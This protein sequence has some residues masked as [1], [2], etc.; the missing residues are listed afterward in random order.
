M[1]PKT[2][3]SVMHLA[4]TAPSLDVFF[5][6][7][8]VSNT[9][10]A[11]GYVT[12]AYSA[13]DKGTFAVKF[14]K[15]TTDSVVA[16]V[17]AITYDSLNYYTFLIY[18]EAVNGPVKAS[19]IKDDYS[20]ITRDQAHFRFFHGSPNVGAVDI[21]IDGN[22]VADHRQLA[23]NISYDAYNK[24]TPTS[25]GVYN[26]E[27]KLS[28]T[29]TVIASFNVDLSNGNAY[30]IYLKGVDGGTG[31]SQLALGLLRAVG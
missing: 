19:R 12:V 24:Y 18:N 8:K 20:T 21:Y 17:P 7:T 28:G 23:D 15:A 27:V 31:T 11:P 14:K 3:I 1:T 26:V 22:K 2:Y 4:P 30:T 5:S 16:E 13:V 10:F 29:S 9:P 25:S 6:D